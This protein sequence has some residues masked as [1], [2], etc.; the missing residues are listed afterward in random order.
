MSEVLS[1][2]D[3]S[4]VE[5]PLDRIIIDSALQPRVKGIDDAHVAVL[6]EVLDE[7]PPV[8]VVQSDAGLVLVGGGHTLCAYQN[9]GRET[10]PAE[11]IARP[12]DGDLLALAFRENAK[13][14]LAYTGD[15]RNA[16]AV[17]LLRQHPDWSDRRIGTLA[18]RRQPTVARIRAGLEASAQIEQTTTRV[19]RG[20][21]TYSVTREEH[22]Q[23]GE[24][25]PDR[26]PLSDRLFTPR[27]RRN[28]GKVARYLTRV[29]DSLENQF[30][31]SGLETAD[32]AAE[33]CRLVLG[34]EAATGLAERLGPAAQN[35][36]DVAVALGYAI[37]A[38]DDE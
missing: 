1:S 31:L 9:S 6:C 16:F 15:D 30:D 19:G 12:E 22:R 24:L 3:G 37:E 34:L 5:L 10:I 8:K 38:E 25:A 14:G 35:V 2:S 26:E 18:G 27:E 7:L 21:Y 36:V 17:H 23:P 32:A 13:F 28:Q 29:A 4:S 11:V 33:A 20:G